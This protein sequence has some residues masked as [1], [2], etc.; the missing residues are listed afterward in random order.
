VSSAGVIFLLLSLEIQA[1]NDRLSVN[2]LGGI[3]K[4]DM[5]CI[6]D[7]YVTITHRVKKTRYIIR[8]IFCKRRKMFVK[9]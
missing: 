5:S 8:N 7:V 9:F 4:R 3:A 1:E 2:P 6:Y